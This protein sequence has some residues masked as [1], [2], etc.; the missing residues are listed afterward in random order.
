M[1]TAEYLTPSQLVARWNNAVTTGTLSNWRSQ[2]RGPEF[3]KFGRSIRYS[4]AAVL[5]YE[6]GNTHVND[7][8][9]EA[10]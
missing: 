7:N 3:V 4:L 8:E 10:K 1:S 9:P 5:Q 2:K 6:A